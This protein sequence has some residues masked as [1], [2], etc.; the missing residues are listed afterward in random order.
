MIKI[1]I[2]TEFSD[3]PGGRYVHEGPYSGEEFRKIFLEPI[4]NQ[5]K[6]SNERIE[7]DLDGG[8]GYLPSFLDESFGELARDHK[9]EDA[10]ERFSFIS[11]DQPILV[12]DIR[13]YMHS[14]SRKARE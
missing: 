7:V 5:A 14:T 13:L 6:E 8:F 11:N 10:W 3:A 12:E 4:Y 1:K 2:A 9:D